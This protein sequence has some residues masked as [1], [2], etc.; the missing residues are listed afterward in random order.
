MRTASHDGPRGELLTVPNDGV[1]PLDGSVDALHILLVRSHRIDNLIVD[2]V[3]KLD[4]RGM[5]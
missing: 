4:R 3:H 5:T 2:G 1:H